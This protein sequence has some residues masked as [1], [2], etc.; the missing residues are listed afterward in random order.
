VW[1]CEAQF[2]FGYLHYKIG[3]GSNGG[4]HRSQFVPMF[5]QVESGIIALAF[6]I[7]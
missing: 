4:E 3:S 5:R 7:S 6:A 2:L 1:G